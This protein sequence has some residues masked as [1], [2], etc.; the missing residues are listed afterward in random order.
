MAEGAGGCS[1]RDVLRWKQ[2]WCPQTHQVERSLLNRGPALSSWRSALS[3]SQN[4]SHPHCPEVASRWL[5]GPLGKEGRNGS[6]AGPGAVSWCRAAVFASAKP[7]MDDYSWASHRGRDGST[8]GTCRGICV[9]FGVVSRGTRK[10][11]VGAERVPRDLRTSCEGKRILVG[12]R[13]AFICF[14]G[15]GTKHAIVW[16]SVWAYGRVEH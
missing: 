7:A 12:G 6:R 4:W 8:I 16:A 9:S 1:A 15:R 2:A 5:Q 10:V 13:G 14:R 3:L 11:L